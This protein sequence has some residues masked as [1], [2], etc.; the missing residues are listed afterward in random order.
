MSGARV[1]FCCLNL[2][3]VVA[4]GLLCSPNRLQAQLVDETILD[5]L[6]LRSIG[7]A[8]MGGRIHDL[9]VVEDRPWIFY[10]GSASGGLWK[11]TNNGTTWDPVFDDQGTSSI[12]D[13]ALA[14]SDPEIVWVGTGEPNN[15][16]SSSFGDGV[17]KSTDGGKT[18]KHVGLRDTHHVGRIVIHPRD[19]DTVY[20]AALGHLWGPNEER[21]LFKTTDGGNTWE[22]I[23]YIDEDTGVVNVA[24]DPVNPRI[25]YAAA[26]QRRRT[27]W[28]FSGGGPGS[29]LYKSSDGGK[30]WKKLTEGIP[31]GPTGRIGIDV[32]RSD[33]RILYALIENREGGVFRSEDRGE[34]WKRVNELNPRPMYY[35]QIWIDP[36]DSRHIYVLGGPFYVSDDG[37]R[38]FE[39]NTAMTPTYGVGVHGDHHVLWIDPANAEHLILG[40][41]G[42]LYVSWDRSRT[43]DKVNNLPIAQFYAVGVDMQKPYFI[44]GGAQDTHSWGG[45]SATRHHIGI[46]NSDWVQIGCCDGMYQR[47]DPTDPNIIYTESQGGDIVRLNRKTGD[48]K[49]IKPHPGD[50]E[51]EYRF[52]WASPILISPHDP[53][54]VYLG[55]NRLFISKDR[56]ETWTATEDLTRAEDRDKLSIMGVV[57]DE[58]TLSR[59]DGV[60]AWGTITTVAESPLTPGLLY[61]GTDDGIVH[62][63]RDG[64]RTWTSLQDRFAGVNEERATVSRVVASHAEPGRGYVTFDRHQLDDFS[65]YVFTTDDYGNT[66]KSIAGNLPQ[67][68]W[69]NVLAEHPRNPNLLFVGTETGLFVSLDRGN[70]WIRLTGNFPTVPVDDLVIHPRDNDL[71][72]GTHGRSIYI[73]DDLAPLEQ[74]SEE[75]LA[76]EVHLFDI[77]P[78]MEFVLVKHESY[79]AQ[80]QFIGANPPF[81]AVISYYLKSEPAGDV[82]LSIV[83]RSGKALREISGTKHPGVN[84]VSWDLRLA[85][86]ERAFWLTSPAPEGVEQAGGPLVPPGRYTVRLKLGEKELAKPLEVEADPLFPVPEE[87]QVARYEFLVTVNGLRQT[88][89]E[90][91]D[92]TEAISEQ[93]KSLLE[94]TE[95]DPEAPEAVISAARTIAEES[96]KIRRALAGPRRDGTGPFFDRQSLRSRASR[97]FTNLDGRVFTPFGR[98]AVRQGTLSGPTL[99]QRERLASLTRQLDEQLESLNRLSQTAVSDLDRQMNE[100]NLPHI[101]VGAPV[102][103]PR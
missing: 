52:H 63:S 62:V 83:D 96:E 85:G 49:D 86:P 75:V 27:P 68:G 88:I 40:G 76:S 32:Y 70:R 44:Y 53:K 22:K 25:L 41:D 71:V 80:R 58:T 13:L 72:V 101:K 28:G 9:A 37:G 2:A 14:P 16:Q 82:E 26:Y 56:G 65:P 24:M 97:L 29:G 90:A 79:G 39:Q 55:G 11:T 60:A 33:P 1:F 64:G 66:W 23:L 21:G 99:V 31:D 10:I 5:N 42:G 7:P 43:W 51:S 46:I 30:T 91:I 59:H 94:G 93:V 12:G 3:L 50:G 34:S 8:V 38:T 15:R 4:V 19:P 69:V 20:V 77:R 78:A 48:Q 57:P 61:V 36:S 81:G 102:R 35:S 92:S 95:G 6:L 67:V 47:V 100:A 54:T 87:E 84:R 103:R 98:N 89:Q 17:Y 45:P 73:L 18:W 74:L